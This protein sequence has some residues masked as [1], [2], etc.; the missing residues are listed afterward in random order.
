M[1][2]SHESLAMSCLRGYLIGICLAQRIRF[3]N[4]FPLFR[5]S[6]YTLLTQITCP[7]ERIHKVQLINPF[8]DEATKETKNLAE[9]RRTHAHMSVMV[10]QMQYKRFSIMVFLYWVKFCFYLLE[11]KL[12]TRCY[13]DS[14]IV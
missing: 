13:N 9:P 14:I 5:R 6:R 10:N 12:Y 2:I 7:R 3:G 1:V 11:D 8:V 4:K